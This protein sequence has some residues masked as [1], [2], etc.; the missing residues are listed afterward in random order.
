MGWQLRAWVTML[1]WCH[2]VRLV[3]AGYPSQQAYACI[4]YEVDSGGCKG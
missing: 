4:S 2:F 1:A 3:F